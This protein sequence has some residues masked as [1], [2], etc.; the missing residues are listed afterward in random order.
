[1]I[2]TV[3]LAWLVGL[4]GTLFLWRPGLYS[5][6]VAVCGKMAIFRFHLIGDAPRA[7]RADVFGWIEVLLEL[8]I[9]SFAFFGPAKHLFQRQRAVRI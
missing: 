1:M 4:V 5:F 7:A 8:V 3:L 9:F 6:L 2:G